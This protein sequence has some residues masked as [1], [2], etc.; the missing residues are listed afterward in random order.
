V[1][2]ELAGLNGRFKSSLEHPMESAKVELKPTSLTISQSFEFDT[3]NIHVVLIRSK[4]MIRSGRHKK[5]WFELS[6]ESVESGYMKSVSKEKRQTQVI[7]CNWVKPKD[8][9][10]RVH[11]TLV[12]GE[13]YIEVNVVSKSP[14]FENQDW[15]SS[16][17]ESIL[18]ALQFSIHSQ[19]EELIK[20]PDFALGK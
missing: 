4:D 14:K 1:I 2:H 18:K 12:H 3:A 9:V 10:K 13:I 17:A 5:R 7:L 6:D 16:E 15:I 11:L 8:D 20:L 19:Y